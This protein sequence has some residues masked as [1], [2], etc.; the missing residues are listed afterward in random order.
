MPATRRS[1]RAGRT[2]AKAEN[3]LIGALRQ[4][5]ARRPIPTSGQ[6]N[7]LQLR[8]FRPREQD[9]GLAAL[10]QQRRPE[11]NASIQQFPAVLIARNMGF[12]E[13][14]FFELDEGE[15]AAAGAAP[16]VLTAA[17]ARLRAMGSAGLRTYI[18]NNG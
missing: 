17:D 4:L 18:W 3:M 1:R 15:R 5:F 16:E 8:T 2:R 11:Y 14:A 12:T 10:L 6:Q 9:C 13:R 7:F